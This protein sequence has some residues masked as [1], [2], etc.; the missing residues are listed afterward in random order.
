MKQA[1]KILHDKNKEIYDLKQ[2]IREE[3]HQKESQMLQ[4]E[5]QKKEKK[6][7]EY[8]E[9]IK[10]K[11]E[12]FKDE[13][14][15]KEKLERDLQE[16]EQ[17]LKIKKIK[18]EVKLKLPMI[19]QRQ[20]KAEDLFILQCR[21]KEIKALKKEE[22]E[23]RINQIIENLSIRPKVDIDPERVKQLTDNLTNRYNTKRDETDR[24]VLFEN[25]GYTVDKLMG[26]LRYKVSTVLGEAGLLNRGY[27]NDFLRNLY[28]GD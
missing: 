9:E 24:V 16:K 27:T 11:S 14:N 28:K 4:I 3:K 13:K 6:L 17:Q 8:Y 26:D 23:I 7:K 22:D 21:A 1:M 19:S 12:K 20:N 5:L 15:E 10:Q 25:N 2:F 18:E